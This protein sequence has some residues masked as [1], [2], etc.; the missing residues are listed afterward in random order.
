MTTT[1]TRVALGAS[2][3]A[4]GLGLFT[5]GAGPASAQTPACAPGWQRMAGADTV[6][7]SATICRQWHTG[8]LTY[9][10]YDKFNH[11]T[12]RVPVTKVVRTAG[13]PRHFSYSGTD[14][15]GTTFRVDDRIAIAIV[16]RDG[17][18]KFY[19]RQR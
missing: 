11:S 6:H 19:E 17:T 3:V 16:G 14:R 15:S 7:K 10:G 2:S 5:A 13:H 4:I 8:T 9:V 18:L 1:L 12:T